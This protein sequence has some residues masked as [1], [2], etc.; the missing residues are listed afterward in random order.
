MART[1]ESRR[2]PPRAV[3]IRRLGPDDLAAYRALRLRGLAE[4]PEAFTSSVEEEAAKPPAALASRLAPKAVSPRDVVLG[5]FVGGALVGIVGLEVDP[6][7]KVR[8]K[9]HVFGM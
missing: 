3:K 5:A 1:V 4:H 8:H 6:R 7:R 9:G 2:E